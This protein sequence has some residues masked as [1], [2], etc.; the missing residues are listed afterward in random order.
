M[1]GS[2]LEEE[3]ATTSRYVF[4]PFARSMNIFQQHNLLLTFLS[5]SLGQQVPKPRK[6]RRPKTASKSWPSS[7]S[8]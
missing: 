7:K 2:I 6:P 3:E 1:G 5:L 4:L 8:K